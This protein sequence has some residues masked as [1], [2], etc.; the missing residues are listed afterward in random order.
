MAINFFR[1]AVLALALAVSACSENGVAADKSAD[2]KD[3]KATADA[4]IP[5]EVAKPVRGEML[6][7]YSG[8]AT[9]DAEADAKI[10]AKVGGEV[11]RI[12]VEE[13]DHV[14]AGQVLAVL[15][16]TAALQAA[17]TPR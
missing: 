9:L 13:G 15:E 14:K 5:V 3:A 12:L 10:V 8:T 17:Q 2:G 4:S 11:L 16:I 7:M 6:A 1:A